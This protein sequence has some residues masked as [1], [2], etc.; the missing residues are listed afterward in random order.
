MSEYI[1]TKNVTKNECVRSQIDVLSNNARDPRDGSKRW[2]WGKIKYKKFGV[3]LSLVQGAAGILEA[4][5]GVGV[6]RQTADPNK[7]YVGR[8]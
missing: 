6:F 3:A 5:P 8:F 7:H 4:G 2:L 1:A